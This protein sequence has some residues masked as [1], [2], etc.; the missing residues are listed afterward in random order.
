[1]GKVLKKNFSQIQVLKWNKSSLQ[2][3]GLKMVQLPVKF[4]GVAGNSPMKRGLKAV[5]SCL[6]EFSSDLLQVIPQ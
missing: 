2:N 6:I 4:E 1:M 5:R 3:F